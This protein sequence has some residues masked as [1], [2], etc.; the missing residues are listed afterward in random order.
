MEHTN[1][2]LIWDSVSIRIT[3][4]RHRQSNQRRM[5]ESDENSSFLLVSG[6]ETRVIIQ[7]AP[8]LLKA[9][10]LFH[11][12]R[13][14]RIVMDPLAGECEYTLIAYDPI[15]PQNM[16]REM[17]RILIEENPFDQVTALRLVNDIPFQHL[18]QRML[19]AW[20]KSRLEERLLLKGIFYE[21][22]HEF[23]AQADTSRMAV[24][25]DMV[26]WTKQYLQSHY[27]QTN[28]ILH[29]AETLKIS[30]SSLHEQFR[31]RVGMS[32]Q[33]YLTGLR[34]EAAQRML[35]ESTLSISEIAIACGLQDK[36]YFFHA[37]R[38]RFGMTPGE[39]RRQFRESQKASRQGCAL[40]AELP[41]Q[42]QQTGVLIENFGRIHHYRS[43]PERIVCLG[44]AAAEMCASLGAESRICALSEAEESIRDCAPRVR[45]TLSKATVLSCG[46]D[47]RRVP[48]YESVCA[49]RPEIVVGT[50][51]SFYERSGVADAAV[52]ERNGI[53]IYA[54]SA[55]CKLNSTFEDVY[56][57][58]LNLGKILGRDAHAK[59]MIGEMRI[60]EEQ[61]RK[62]V[63]RRTS[64]VRVFVFD[65]MIHGCAFTCGQSLENYMILCAGGRN[66]FGDRTS[67]FTTVTWQE[68]AQADP[69]VI[70]VHRFYDGDDGERKIDLLRSCEELRDTSA[71]RNQRI[72]MIGIKR[73]FPGIDNVDTTMQ[74]AEWFQ[75]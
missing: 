2:L 35:R 12:G 65:A 50:S 16:G 42:V 71:I 6:K 63:R 67:Q 25:V 18:F 29:L 3:D 59:S 49:C 22:L 57:D 47:G 1:A 44:Y 48:S 68:V 46:T 19:A 17:T 54:L 8:Y 30:R 20:K 5:E 52:F 24:P 58:I 15:Y 32:P 38:R 56:G 70:L 73:V 27:T 10:G 43:I 34:M 23:Y 36:N 7:N 64:P 62:A 4:V 60:K 26:L 45:E 72:H 13:N 21:M 61:L 69:E 55:T 31:R 33:Q 75:Q 51:Y 41:P 39:Y 37:Y 14:M 66:I 28:S 11:V 9:S 74:M 53:H 40:Q